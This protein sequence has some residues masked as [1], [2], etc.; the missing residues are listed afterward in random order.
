MKTALH[1]RDYEEYLDPEDIYSLIAL[2]SCVNK[3]FAL[4]SRAFI[5]LESLQEIPLHRRNRY[6]DLATQLF[7]RNIP[8][9]SRNLPKVECPFCA[10]LIPD[11]SLVCSGCNTHFPSCVLTGRPVFDTSAA[12]SCSRCT[13]LVLKC[14]MNK[15]SL[16]RVCPLCHFPITNTP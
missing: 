14:E 3:N 9:E 12:W 10:A 2:T 13:H 4:A 5:K 16:M 7:S 11:Y 1:L 15:F 8:K 6:R